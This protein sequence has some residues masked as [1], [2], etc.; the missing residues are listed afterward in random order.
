MRQQPRRNIQII[1]QQV[2]LGQAQLRKIYFVQ[3]GEI[4]G[5]PSTV[6][7]VFSIL[8]GISSPAG[9]AIAL[10]FPEREGARGLALGGIAAALRGA[11][12]TLRLD[13]VFA[14]ALDFTLVR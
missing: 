5:P 8:R 6:S 1:L 12:T 14:L 10:L 13:A 3:I 7:V 4:T 9:C 11:A 2:S